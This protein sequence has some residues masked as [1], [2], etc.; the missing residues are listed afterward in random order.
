MID[1]LPK[2][3]AKLAEL[4]CTFLPILWECHQMVL[5]S[6]LTGELVR[7]IELE[8][9]GAAMPDP[10]SK[11]ERS[12]IMAAVRGTGNQSTELRMVRL[13][14]HLGMTGWRRGYPVMGRPDFVFP[15]R[16]IVVFV[17]G[18]FWHG[19]PVHCRRPSSNQTYWNA[20]IAR[21]RKRDQTVRRRLKGRGWS[22]LNV[23]EH[24]LRRDAV[25]RLTRRLVRFFHPPP[26][27]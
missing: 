7:S 16:R 3:R 15:H 1:T 23:W 10:F 17:D 2:L 9:R 19:C 14:R 27:R 8:P 4:Y 26:T 6:L 18:C 13:F 11:T 21:N 25:E 5:V 24:E 20:K 22:V 12:A